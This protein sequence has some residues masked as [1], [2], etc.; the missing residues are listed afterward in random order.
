MAAWMLGFCL[1]LGREGGLV[2]KG[3]VCVGRGGWEPRC[4]GSAWL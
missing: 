3:C 1:A 2:V 4:S